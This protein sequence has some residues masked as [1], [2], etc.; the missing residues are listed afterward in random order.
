MITEFA[1]PPEMKEPQPTISKGLQEA[2]G[3][4]EKGAQE[5]MEALRAKKE[6]LEVGKSAEVTVP[7]LI[8]HIEK[9]EEEE[10][11]EG[12]EGTGVVQKK[13]DNST[14]REITKGAMVREKEGVQQPE[15]QAAGTKGSTKED[16]KKKPRSTPSA[17][18]LKEEKR[19]ARI[20]EQERRC[21]EAT[22][23]G[24]GERE[25]D[26]DLEDA[27]MSPDEG[28]K[29]TEKTKK[30]TEESDTYGKVYTKTHEERAERS[31]SRAER[32]EQEE[33]KKREEVQ[34]AA[35]KAEADRVAQEEAK[36][37]IERAQLEEEE[38]AVQKRLE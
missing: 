5:C 26:I 1:D 11:E 19:R 8:G 16:S 22:E 28:E 17:A 9:V 23:K 18:R 7:K 38:L 27:M 2:L 36:H 21:K 10:I 34:K 33:Q 37:V 25:G 3:A 32:K 13:G 31:V 4:I 35:A 12:V 14:R 20:K 30:D 29:H 24:L 15:E 6:Q